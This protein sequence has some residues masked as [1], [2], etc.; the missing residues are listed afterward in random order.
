MDIP[1]W[2]HLL[3]MSSGGIGQP[4]PSVPPKID[5]N[6]EQDSVPV[7]HGSYTGLRY[8]PL[9]WCLSPSY[10]SVWA[11]GHNHTGEMGYVNCPCCMLIYILNE[12][13]SSTRTSEAFHETFV[14]SCFYMNMFS[15]EDNISGALGSIEY[16][17]PPQ[18][19]SSMPVLDVNDLMGGNLFEQPV[20]Q[21]ILSDNCTGMAADSFH[22]KLVAVIYFL[23]AY[24]TV[25]TAQPVHTTNNY[26]ASPLFTP[27]FDA[28]WHPD[29]DTGAMNNLTQPIIQSITYEGDGVSSTEEDGV[30]T[31]LDLDLP[32][33]NDQTPYVS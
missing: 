13:L 17:L 8:D 7:A 26:Y 33:Q 23:G 24:M 4:V 12:L 22:C 25:T 32:T 15:S 31:F 18:Q 28:R 14:P 6:D 27:G 11:N 9:Y 2:Q 21:F 5:Q 16:A 30:F 19:Q 20:S 3:N 29:T 1:T 10:S